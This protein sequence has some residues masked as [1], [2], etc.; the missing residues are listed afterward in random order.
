MPINKLLNKT[1]LITGSAVRIGRAIALAFAEQGANLV[2][3]YNKS[4]F[5]AEEL[6]S[7]L[8]K[9][10]VMAFTIQ[11]DF[12]QS[13]QYDSFI[14]ECLEKAGSLDIL[15]NNASVFPKISLND[16]TFANL[17]TDMEI[18][19][20]APFA[21]SRVFASKVKSGSIINLLDQR[22]T[23]YDWIHTG[24]I[25][26]KHVLTVLTKMSALAFAPSIRVNGIAPGLILSPP[27]EPVSYIENLAPTVPLKRHGDP[28]DVAEAAV[29]LAEC[30]YVTGDVIYVD[31]G[32]HLREFAS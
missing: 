20:W 1:V 27:G 30:D 11:A 6:K 12:R 18:N 28:K 32:R 25:L 31:G 19:A 21:L 16:L 14:D 26:S 24:Y 2:I 15:V 10:D 23:S 3:H 7:E 22:I 17:M 8:I 4:K 13:H 29:F 5:K 9:K